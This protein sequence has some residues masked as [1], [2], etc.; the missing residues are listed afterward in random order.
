MPRLRTLIPNAQ[1]IVLSGQ[2]QVRHQALACGADA[3]ISKMDPPDKLLH[4][5]ST[6]QRRWQRSRHAEHASLVR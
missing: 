4:A 2:P 5:L 3:F 1:V 6:C